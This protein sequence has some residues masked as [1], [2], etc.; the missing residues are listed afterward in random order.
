VTTALQSPTK[1]TF[2]KFGDPS[3]FSATSQHPWPSVGA[4]S[5]N[6]LV[7]H[8]WDT[9]DY[10]EYLKG[11]QHLNL[12]LK[13]RFDAEGIKFAFPTQTLYLRK[14]AEQSDSNRSTQ[15]LEPNT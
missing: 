14:E 2:R 9:T 13:R 8:W 3:H 5:L 15:T 6:I 12:E 1:R 4:S 11:I 10:G 7:V